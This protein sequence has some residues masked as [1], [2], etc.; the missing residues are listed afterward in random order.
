[1]LILIF[2]N[3]QATHDIPVF[4]NNFTKINAGSY[5]GEVDFGLISL[6]IINTVYF[7]A[8]NVTNSDGV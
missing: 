7:S 6:E 4:R 8:R 5:P 3:F 1:M 2:Y